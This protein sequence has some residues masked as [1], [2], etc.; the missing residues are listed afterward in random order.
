MKW[1]TKDKLQKA[2]FVIML[3]AFVAV[4]L[5]GYHNCQRRVVE[6]IFS[7]GWNSIPAA[8]CN[9]LPSEE[10]FRSSVGRAADL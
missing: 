10:C 4:M 1:K 3:I 8:I 7:N 5:W 6:K 2:A 9:K